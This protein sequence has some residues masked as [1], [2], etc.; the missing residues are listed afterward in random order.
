MNPVPTFNFSAFSFKLKKNNFKLIKLNF[1][2]LS[3]NYAQGQN[4]RS[5]W[6]KANFKIFNLIIKGS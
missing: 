5:F 2:F 1:C 6:S 4:R 3:N